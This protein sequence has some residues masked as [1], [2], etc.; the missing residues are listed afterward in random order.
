[1]TPAIEPLTRAA[2]LDLNR[3]NRTFEQL[4]PRD[5]LAWCVANVPN[6]WVQVSRFSVDDMLI[7]DLLCRYIEPQHR[8]P[9]LFLDTLHHFPETLDL[10]ARAAAAYSLDVRIC[11]PLQGQTQKQFTR[12]YGE[13]LWQTNLAK[14]H[15]VTQQEPQEWGLQQSG[16]ISW[17]AGICRDR[18]ADSL[19]QPIFQLDQQ[20]RLQINPLANWTRR[21]TWAYMFEYDVMYNPLHDCGYA[22]IGD[23]PLSRP[24]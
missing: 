9:V 24:A 13:A 19:P 11:Q 7:T 10:A 22:D 12:L 14:F 18:A 5:I 6:Q 1:M 8:V 23:Q 16:A 17:I 3:L 20:Q 2:H 15:Q 21:E 4:H